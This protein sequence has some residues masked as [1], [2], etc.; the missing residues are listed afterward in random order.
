MKSET[1]NATATPTAHQLELLRHLMRM[2]GRRMRIFGR[3]KLFL[4][5]MY[6][7]NAGEHCY[8][9]GRQGKGFDQVV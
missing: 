3:F 8:N 5:R 7:D 2:R 1:K 4:K 9:V 6:Y